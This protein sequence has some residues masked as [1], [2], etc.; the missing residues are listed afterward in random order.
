MNFHPQREE[1]VDVNL[2]PLIDVVF[3]LAMFPTAEC[4]IKQALR[5]NFWTKHLMKG[6]GYISNQDST[7]LLDDCIAR[8]KDGQSL[9]LI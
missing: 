1:E 5:E 3:L 7:Q 9:I 2:T 6:V 4:V 8:L